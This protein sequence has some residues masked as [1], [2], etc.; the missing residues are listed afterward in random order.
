MRR[1]EIF[2]HYKLTKFVQL[3]TLGA[4]TVISFI[5]LFTNEATRSSLYSSKSLFTLACVLWAVLLLSFLWLFYDFS[6]MQFFIR[7]EHELNKAAY[8]DRSTALPNRNSLDDFFKLNPAGRDIDSL[9]CLLM[10]ISNLYEI[11]DKNGHDA[12]DIALHQFSEIL[13]RTG[14]DHAFVGRNGGN[15]FLALIENCSEDNMKSFIELISKSVSSYNEKND[16]P[17][18]LVISYTYTLNSEIHATRFSELVTYTYRKT[19][20]G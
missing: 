3:G 1:H 13:E 5:L 7:E 4:A 16:E 9:G 2:K 10:S 18:K 6:K 19:R 15:E 11:N 14:K 17:V 20:K 12:G 8:L